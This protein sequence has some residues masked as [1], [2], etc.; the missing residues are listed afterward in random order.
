MLT[1]VLSP[2]KT[3][4]YERPVPP[5]FEALE[6]ALRRPAFAAEAGQLVG[7]LRALDADGVGRLMELSPA[8]AQL[9]VARFAA[10]RPRFTR[11]NSRAALLAFNG[12]V[13]EGLDACSLDAAALRWADERV[14]I[15]S[16]LYGLLRPL[17][18][19]QPYRLEMGRPLPNPR[20]ANLY[21]FWGERL[22]LA[23]N[24]MAP[25]QPVV[26]L[27]S[28]EYAR[29]MLC[30]ALKRP[31]IEPVFEE[32]KGG[33][34]K[35]V[36]F[37]AKRARGL[38]AR[39]AVEHR[40]EVAADLRGFDIEGYQWKAKHSTAQRWVYQRQSTPSP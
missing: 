6:G 23:L 19:L 10:W 39:F 31:V 9:N 25:G 3:L 24:R 37:Y 11:A 12:D 35:V 4:D 38:M 29:A 32:I 22:A 13:Y 20:G 27:A 33:Q 7:L 28:Q 17:D 1:F 5:A 18:R 30:S 26:N 16:G 34:A 14:R 36:S 15:L 8:L 2:A 40:I 21:A